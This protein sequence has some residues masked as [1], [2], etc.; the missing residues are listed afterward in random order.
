LV[1]LGTNDCI[2]DKSV[3]DILE[4]LKQVVDTLHASNPNMHV[5]LAK[6]IPLTDFQDCLDSVNKGIVELILSLSSPVYLVDMAE[7]FN[8][9]TDTW[10]DSNQPMKLLR[11]WR[12][13]G[14]KQCL[15]TY[16]F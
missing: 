5:F 14:L 4:E 12:K 1:H 11:K 2:E 9:D 13:S 16:H 3:I 7:G 6:L 10:G 15:Q 8:V